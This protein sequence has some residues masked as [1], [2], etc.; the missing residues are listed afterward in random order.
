MNPRERRLREREIKRELVRIMRES[1]ADPREVAEWL[2]EDFGKRVRP[3]WGR[4][5]KA[6]MDDDV[7]PQDLALFME[8]SGISFDEE[9]V[10]RRE[11]DSLRR[12]E[13]TDR[14]G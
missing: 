2:W 11:Y 10:W 9:R 12:R 4:L 5:E 14:S 13:E 8:E 3:E 7:T 1:G 6:M